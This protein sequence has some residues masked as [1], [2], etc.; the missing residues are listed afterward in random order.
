VDELQQLEQLLNELLSGIQE[1][2]QSGET[3]SDEFQGTIAQE[4]T[5][6]TTRIDE[7]RAQQTPAIPPLDKSMDSSVIEAFKYD[8]KR[9]KLFVQFKG[10]YPNA[11]GHIY[12]YDNTPPEI[13]ELFRRGAIPAK[14]KGFNRWGQWW[15]GKVPSMGSSM[16]VL[17]K[18]LG[19]P[20][21]RLT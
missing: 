11:E 9:N 7:L 8:P 2:M 21:Q 18:G 16:N 20:Y 13:F 5:Y 1:V 19:L 12:S 17:L 4:L 15:R 3:L 14:T 6:L 10:K